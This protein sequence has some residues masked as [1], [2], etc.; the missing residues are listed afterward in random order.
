MIPRM[1]NPGTMVDLMSY[2]LPA[3]YRVLPVP[4]QSARA[5]AMLIAIGLQE[6]K[7]LAR[8]QYRNGPARGFWQ[9]EERGALWGVVKHPASREHVINVLRNLR[10]GATMAKNLP[11]FHDVLS[12]N[13]VLACALARLLLWTDSKPIPDR[14]EPN[15]A[16]AMYMRTW[17]PGKPHRETWDAYFSEAWDRV[18]FSPE[19]R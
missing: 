9:F 10:Y 8:R 17:N 6:T 7:F 5:S 3:A 14:G 16:W 18:D 1:Y 2:I 13:D 19:L 12:H 11:L 4:M 15:T